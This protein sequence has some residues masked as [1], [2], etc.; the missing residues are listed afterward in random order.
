MAYRWA[1]KDIAGDLDQEDTEK[2]K[3]SQRNQERYRKK[4]E[5]CAMLKKVTA[6]WQRVDNKYGLL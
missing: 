2:E 6:M 1:V 4:Q 3:G 5:E